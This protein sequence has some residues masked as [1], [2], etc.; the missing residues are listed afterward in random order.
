[1]DADPDRRY[2]DGAVAVQVIGGSV[3]AVVFGGDQ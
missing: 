3:G 2:P 1:V